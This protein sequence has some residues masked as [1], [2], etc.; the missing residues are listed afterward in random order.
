MSDFDVFKKEAEKDGVKIFSMG[1]LK[2]PLPNYCGSYNLDY[3]LVTPFPEGRISEIFGWEGTCK[4]TL[5]LEII[6]QALIKGKMCLYVN[7][8]KNLNL[9]LM[10]T[11]RPLRPFLEKAIENL[12]A[13]SKNKKVPH[14][15][16]LFW[17]ANA[18]TGEQAMETMR[19]FSA[20]FPES[21][22]VLD[23]IDAAQPEAV[24]AGEIGDKTMGK[25]AQLMADAMHKLIASAEEN[26]VSLIFI[27]QFRQKMTMYGDPSITP[28]G[29]A[30]KFYA[31]QRIELLKP[32]KDDLITD[33]DG[34]KIGVNIRYKIV[35]NKSAPDG[36]EGS[37]SILLKNGLFKERELV[38]KCLNFGILKFG[39]RGGRQVLLPVLD[40]G[41]ETGEFIT[42]KQFDAARRLILDTTLFA[43]LD[44]LYRKTINP[45][46]HHV[47]DF[48]NEVS[49]TEE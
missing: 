26:S 31:S 27:N 43:Y 40:N 45:E 20:M 3:D 16:C 22:V 36:V 35:K 10:K 17:L 49:D 18:N 44:K 8:E 7:M 42:L 12:E 5:A 38:T 25:H 37:F 33:G 15:D 39:G 30:I 28:G 9:S 46:K 14:Q 32:R 21:V 1:E 41:K 4:T 2:D 13:N 34:E 19:K 24:L 6:G 23:S 29:F 47:D 48:V 11:I